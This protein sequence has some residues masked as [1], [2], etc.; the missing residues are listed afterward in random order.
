MT[1][2]IFAYIE[3]DGGTVS[4]SAFE[5]LTAAATIDS[6]AGVTAIVTGTGSELG[7]VCTGISQGYMDVWKIDVKT[8]KPNA[9]TTRQVLKQ[10]LPENSIVLIPH[11][12][13]GMDL[14]PGLSILLEKPYV[15]DVLGFKGVEDDRI[16]AVREEHA[17]QILTTVGCDISKGAVFT[18]RSGAFK[19]SERLTDTGQVTDKT[20]DVPE[21]IFESTR[22][23]FIELL[24]E[25]PGD[26]DITKADIL[27]SVGRGI[28]DDDNLPMVF[29]LAKTL[30][31]EVACTRPLADSNWMEK[32]RQVGSSGKTVKPKLYL[33]LGISGS[34]QHLAGIKGSPFL[35]AVNKNPRAPI[36]NVADVGVVGNILDMVPKLTG[37]INELKK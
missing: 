12:H 37:K 8:E 18:C 24:Q 31:A 25:D 20:G 27:V 35:L 7:D 21:E 9:E 36:F 28:Q 13:F 1:N 2:K 33:A 19:T 10:V 14:A 22:I 30:G 23:H 15:A 16:K 5:L 6:N 26:V 11:E 34:F 4:D 29:D 17:G 3:H 32:A